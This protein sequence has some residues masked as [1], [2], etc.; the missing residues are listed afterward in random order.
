[1]LEEAREVHPHL[2]KI[3]L[4]I[5]SVILLELQPILLQ[6][7]GHVLAC[8]PFDV[9]Q[10]QSSECAQ[11]LNLVSGSAL[12]LRG[13]FKV[14]TK[15]VLSPRGK[16]YKPAWLSYEQQTALQFCSYGQRTIKSK[17]GQNILG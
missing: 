2:G 9:H 1:M 11:H 5:Q 4:V 16:Q 15:R 17:V 10:L 8:K 12:R 7:A 6:V 14:L 13:F 3:T